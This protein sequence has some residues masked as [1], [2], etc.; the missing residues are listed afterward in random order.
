[1]RWCGD[2]ST[3]RQQ[4]NDEPDKAWSERQKPSAER[5]DARA[6]GEGQETGG[7]IASAE[8]SD[9]SAQAAKL[10][11]NPTIACAK[12]GEAPAETQERAAQRPNAVAETDDALPEDRVSF[13]PGF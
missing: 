13:L 10:T 8:L 7:S 5:G 11:T 4:L 1:M 2:A 3:A 6:R 12:A 9:P